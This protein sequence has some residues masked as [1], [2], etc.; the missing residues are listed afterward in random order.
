VK[1]TLKT[2]EGS[3]LKMVDLDAPLTCRR[4][5]AM[6]PGMVEVTGRC[7]QRLRRL[8][9]GLNTSHWRVYEGKKEPNWV[10]TVLIID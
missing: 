9:Q 2:K 3:R 1:P 5:V 6:F 7:V 10:R 8:N 4:V